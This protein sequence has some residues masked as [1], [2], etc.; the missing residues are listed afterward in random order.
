MLGSLLRKCPRLE[1][2]LT[3]IF[4]TIPQ[5]FEHRLLK[6][7]QKQGDKFSLKVHSLQ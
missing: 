2:G 3:G 7:E 6:G 1:E 4:K 5:V